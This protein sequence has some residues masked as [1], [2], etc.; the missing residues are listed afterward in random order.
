MNSPYVYC[1]ANPV[2][3]VDPDGRDWTDAEGN[4]ILDHRNIKVYILYD[5]NSFGSQSKQMYQDAVSEYGNGSVAMSNVTTIS[6]FA[7]DWGDMASPDIHEVNLNYHGNNQTVMLNSSKN[8]YITATGDGK[9]N[10]SGT[11]AKNVQDLPIPSGYIGN[12]KLNL[13][14][15]RSN[16]KT[17]YELK[18]NKQTLMESFYNSFNFKSVRGTDKGVSYWYWFSPNRP[19]PQDDSNWQYL[20]RP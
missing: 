4:K 8:Q 10:R 5:P 6:E 7:Q 17:Q 13:N 20:R 16:S 3:Y 2:R 14:T 18:G 11:M 9:T 12:A 1:N 15:C 19:H